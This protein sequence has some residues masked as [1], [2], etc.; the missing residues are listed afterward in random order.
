[1]NECPH[2]IFQVLTKHGERLE[3]VWQNLTW[4]ENIWMG[5][6]VE[7]VSSSATMAV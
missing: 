3:E 4:S 2:L 7:A 5:V 6:S 1:M